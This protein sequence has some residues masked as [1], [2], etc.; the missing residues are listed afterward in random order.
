M[1]DYSTTVYN[2]K[3]MMKEEARVLSLDD[4]DGKTTFYHYKTD[5]EEKKYL[6]KSSPIKEKNMK[7]KPLQ[8]KNNSKKDYENILE[9][10]TD[11]NIPKTAENK[12]E[13]DVAMRG[14]SDESEESEQKR[15]KM[16][17]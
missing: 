16:S 11:K 14:D 4:K 1:A 6:P 12:A 13:K 5:N 8:K 3:S 15:K 9:K 7:P 17:L 2:S 10:T